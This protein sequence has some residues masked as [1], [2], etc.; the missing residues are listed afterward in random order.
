M[1]ISRC[2]LIATFAVVSPLAW[3]QPAGHCPPDC[4]MNCPHMEGTQQGR[5]PG[6]WT[7][8]PYSR[9]YDSKTVETVKGEI[10]QVDE[11]APLRGMS[12][13]VHLTLKT[14]RG[15]V[16]VHLGPARYLDHRPS[17]HAARRR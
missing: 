6:G 7:S 4:P 8:G 17:G 1:T 14:D 5:G 11:V 13:G 16:S 15:P 12:A 3:A 9:L 10:T 2:L